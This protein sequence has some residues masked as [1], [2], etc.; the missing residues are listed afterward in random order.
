MS[1]LTRRAE[2]GF[3]T[4]EWTLGLGLIV[5]PLT[6]LVLTIAP[7]F[8]RASMARL[9][10]NEAARVMVLADDYATGEAEARAVAEEIAANYGFAAGDWCE[11]PGGDGC[12]WMGLS[13][14][15]PG[16]L[17]RSGEVTATVEV[18]IPATTIWFIAEAPGFQWTTEHVERVDDYRSFP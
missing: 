1:L 11:S 8:E 16:A 5:L 10:A 9:I 13:S 12:L 7:W 17:A 4:V 18:P 2:R 6:L 14:T 15:T 3:T